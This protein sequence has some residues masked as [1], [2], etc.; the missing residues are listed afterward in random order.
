[1][2]PPQL[3][4]RNDEYLTMLAVIKTGGKQYKVSPKQKIKI[5]KL[6]GKEGEKVIFEDV[7]LVSDDKKTQIGT[8][9]VPGVKVAGLILKQDKADKIT[10]LKYKAKKRYSVKRGHRQPYTLVEIDSISEA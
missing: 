3:R 5:E 4:G 2:F 10:I 8:P 1:M 9:K 7:L 6:E